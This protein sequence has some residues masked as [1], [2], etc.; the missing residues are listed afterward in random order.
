MGAGFTN[1]NARNAPTRATCTDSPRQAL[2]A[3]SRVKIQR[4]HAETEI[5]QL[6]ERERNA[7][8]CAKHP[9]LPHRLELEAR[10]TPAK[11]ANARIDIGF[12]K[13]IAAETGKMK[14]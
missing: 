8:A 11:N 13:H 4:L 6:Q 12:D 3:V 10:S 9:A 2:H 7:A 1:F 5:K 14:E